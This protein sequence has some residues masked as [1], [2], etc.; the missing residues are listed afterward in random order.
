MILN[1]ENVLATIF[2]KL[3]GFN[4][5]FDN[6]NVVVSNDEY[7][8]IQNNLS[9]YIIGGEESNISGIYEVFFA[10]NEQGY[11]V[12]FDDLSG[13]SL[14]SVLVR[15]EFYDYSIVAIYHTG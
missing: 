1:C 15:G 9:K 14:E 5:S 10:N 11:F 12:T 6:G 2:A 13:N 7:F 8:S 3:R 4:Y